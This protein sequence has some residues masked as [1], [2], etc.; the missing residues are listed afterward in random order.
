MFSLFSLFFGWVAAIVLLCHDASF[1]ICIAHESLPGCTVLLAGLALCFS[2][3]SFRL[4][5]LFFRHFQLRQTKL[6]YL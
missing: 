5:P 1:P 3:N 6:V 2:L 4:L